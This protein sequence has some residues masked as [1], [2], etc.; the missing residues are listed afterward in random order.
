LINKKTFR[1]NRKERISLSR[2]TD[3][4]F[5]DAVRVEKLSRILNSL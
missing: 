4:L 1:I 5:S 2:Y 3:L